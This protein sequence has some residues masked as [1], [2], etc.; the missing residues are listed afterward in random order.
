MFEPRSKSDVLIYRHT[1]EGGGLMKGNYFGILNF[2]TFNISSNC[3]NF[4]LIHNRS[5]KNTNSTLELF[6]CFFVQFD[7]INWTEIT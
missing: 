3:Q 5:Q 6:R 2:T 7:N 1:Q 4:E